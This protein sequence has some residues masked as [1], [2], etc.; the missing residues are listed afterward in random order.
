MTRQPHKDRV[1]AHNV[2]GSSPVLVSGK[3]GRM[4]QSETRH[5]ASPVTV[6][7]GTVRGRQAALTPERKRTALMWAI[8]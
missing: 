6:G 2:T 1:T 3:V 4:R 7:K 5:A 8:G